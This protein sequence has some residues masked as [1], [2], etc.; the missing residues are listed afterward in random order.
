MPVDLQTTSLYR[1]E[2]PGV[3]AIDAEPCGNWTRFVNSSCVPNVSAWTD[4]VG[5]RHTVFFQAMRD[6]G[7][8]E[9]L[10][11]K[12]GKSYFSAAGFK[13]DCP[14]MKRPHA[15]GEAKAMAKAKA[16]K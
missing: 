9:E 2:I 12:Y 16:K 4:T 15:P 10:T 1:F 11:F 13:C 6:V 8:E 14:A 7:P 3:C 5:K